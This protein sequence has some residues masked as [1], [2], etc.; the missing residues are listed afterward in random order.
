[1]KR[2]ISIVLCCICILCVC[3]CSKFDENY[4]YDGH[5]LV[6]K[7]CEKDYEDAYYFSYEFSKDGRVTNKIYNYGIEMSSVEGVYTASKNEILIDITRYDGTVMHYQHK[8]CITD[9]GELVIIYLSDDDQMTEKEMVL[10][11]FDVDF[12]DDNSKLTGNWED[13]KNRGEIWSFNS[14]Y[15]GT[16]SSGEY[17]YK[18][19][20][21]VKGKKLYMAY[22]FV[23]GVKESLVEFKYKLDGNTLTISGEIDGE[24]I[25]YTFERK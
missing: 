20:Y 12:N 11:P 15:T 8:F 16:I 9:R 24:K 17:S 13:T 4:E 18:M 23:E 6:G 14:D 2:V 1:M 10:V 7:W 22:E 21:S 19:Y 3:S 25:E 5:S